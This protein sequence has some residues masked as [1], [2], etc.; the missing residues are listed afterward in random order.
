MDYK[1]LINAKN[2]H[3]KTSFYQ[4]LQVGYCLGPEVRLLAI[5]S[6]LTISTF[7]IVKYSTANLP[8]I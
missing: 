5:R 6:A 1:L 2:A 4:Q 8:V 7:V 3:K